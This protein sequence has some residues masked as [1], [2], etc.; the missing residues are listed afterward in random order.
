M[1]V[2]W[3]LALFAALL[4]AS[5]TVRADTSGPAAGCVKMCANVRVHVQ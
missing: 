4:I 3:A 1:T 2:K 5:D